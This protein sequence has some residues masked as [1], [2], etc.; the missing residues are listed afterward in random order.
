MGM[1]E[2]IY[3]MLDERGTEETL[4]M[5]KLTLGER[6]T[7]PFSEQITGPVVTFPTIVG[8]ANVDSETSIIE[9]M[10]DEVSESRQLMMSSDRCIR[11][12]TSHDHPAKEILQALA[13]KAA[14]K[15]IDYACN[16]DVVKEIQSSLYSPNQ[17]SNGI[18][19]HL[20]DNELKLAGNKLLELLRHKIQ[21]LSIDELMKLRSDFPVLKDEPMVIT[22]LASLIK[23]SVQ[24]DS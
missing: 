5:I 23:A 2:I 14:R 13:K 22:T 21:S 18:T 15:A 1:A 10:I 9:Y 12:I 3:R 7:A 11:L 24:S 19:F 17:T 20:F 16:P 4:P 6:I 8:E